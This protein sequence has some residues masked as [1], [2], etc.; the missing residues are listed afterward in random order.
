[1]KSLLLLVALLFAVTLGSSYAVVTKASN[2]ARKQKAIA[3]FNDPV[4]FQG[5][6]LKG[7]YLFVHDDAAMKRGE[8]CTFVYKGSAEIASKLVAS[9]HCTPVERPKVDSFS[10]RT[11]Q[12]SPGVDEL[13]EIQFRGET[14]A[15]LVPAK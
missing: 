5:V 15:H 10:V 9:F 12:V 14:E 6:I 3:Q 13:R 11:M 8:A 2:P 7:E 1:M 4:R